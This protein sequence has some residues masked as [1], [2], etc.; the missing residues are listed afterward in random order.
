MAIWK[1]HQEWRPKNSTKEKLTLFAQ[2][3]AAFGDLD[4]VIQRLR[5]T[6]SKAPPAVPPVAPVQKK[7]RS[8]YAVSL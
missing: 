5:P 3:V 8:R 1:L 6:P 7:Q 4:S 2:T